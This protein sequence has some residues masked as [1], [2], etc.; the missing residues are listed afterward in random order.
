MQLHHLKHQGRALSTP[1]SF[2]RTTS[3]GQN[4]S[5]VYPHTETMNTVPIYPCFTEDLNNRYQSKEITFVT[6]NSLMVPNHHILT[7]NLRVK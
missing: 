1:A 6:C 5:I 7:Y 2:F 3:L 4:R